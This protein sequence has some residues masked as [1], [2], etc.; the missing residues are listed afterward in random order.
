MQTQWFN[1]KK[2]QEIPA[3]KQNP[4]EMRMFRHR[5]GYL[6]MSRQPHGP[7]QDRLGFASIRGGSISWRWK[8]KLN[9]GALATLLD[10]LWLLF[11][12][13]YLQ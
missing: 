13:M 10:F 1:S 4:R 12:A 5:V 8:A 7:R 6:E 3:Q 9:H 11:L 2:T